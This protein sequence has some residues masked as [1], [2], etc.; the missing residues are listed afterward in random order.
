LAKNPKPRF[1][2]ISDAGHEIW[3]NSRKDAQEW[4]L[5][6]SEI[7]VH[8]TIIECGVKKKETANNDKEKGKS[9]KVMARS[10]TGSVKKE[11]TIKAPR[12]KSC[13]LKS[14]DSQG[15]KEVRKPKWEDVKRLFGT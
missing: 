3:W 4:I 2:V 7:G 14:S 9:K 6:H 8:F 15:K 5:D 13:E 12:E 11:P 1:K 10:T